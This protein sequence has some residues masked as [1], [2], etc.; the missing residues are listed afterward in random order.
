MH[1]TVKASPGYSKHGWGLALD[2]HSDTITELLANQ[3]AMQWLIDNIKDYGW[4][5]EKGVTDTPAAKDPYHLVYFGLGQ[6]KK[7]SVN[8]KPAKRITTKTVIPKKT[9]DKFNPIQ[10]LAVTPKLVAPTGPGNS[11]RLV[12][13]VDAIIAAPVSYHIGQTGPGGG[14]I[15]ITPLTPGNTTG[16]YFEV[17]PKNWLLQMNR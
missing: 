2:I 4:S 14:R 13:T 16:R 12:K 8:L 10:P 5:G 9:K 17:A 15:F 11:M 6:V 1:G 3:N 7:L